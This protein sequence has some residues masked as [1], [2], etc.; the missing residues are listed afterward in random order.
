M[1]KIGVDFHAFDGKF[2]GSR[3]HLIGLYR[4]M[5]SLCPDFEFVFF[6]D[7]V[8]ELR[9]L[10]GFDRPNVQCVRMPSANPLLRLAWQLPILAR[11]H[12]LDILHTQYIVP[13]WPGCRTI[14]TIHDVLFEPYPEYFTPFFVWRSRWLFRRSAQVADAV[15]TVS[16]YSRQE[17]SRRYQVPMERIGLLL[18]AVDPLV[19]YPARDDGKA[20]LKHRNLASKQYLL[21]VGRI[22]PRKDHVTLLKAYAQ[23]GDGAPPL[24]IVGQRDFGN[25]A[26]DQVLSDLPDGCD[27]RILSD[28]DD[29]ELPVL[30]QHAL[31]L[32]YPSRAEGFG[33]PPLEAMACGAPV[34]TTNATALPEVVGDAGLLIQPGDVG[35]LVRELRRLIAQPDLRE[36]LS[37]RSL[38]RSQT[39][40]WAHAADALRQSL[41]QMAAP[42][43]GAPPR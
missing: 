20:M 6:L 34:V 39:F 42:S 26:F 12:R 43:R 30:M 18:N 41:V 13:L 9:T 17:I 40:S 14:V 28:V 7:R 38:V 16:E 1:L 3:S 5:V 11:Q 33:M 2:Q 21:T 4:A 27:V 35:G 32:A 19:F 23:L 10:S 22:E 15:M 25:A 24:V 29:E 37:R 36:E 31:A 8:D